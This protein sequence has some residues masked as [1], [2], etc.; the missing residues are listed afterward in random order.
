MPNRSVVRFQWRAHK[1]LWS[2]SGGRI[3][4]RV[5]GMP[6][7]ELETTGHRSGLT[8][9][10]LITYLDGPS[11]PVVF[12][13]NAGLNRDPAW[14][15]NLAAKPTVR[16]RINRLW[17]AATATAVTEPSERDRL[18]TAAVVANPGYEEYLK[19]IDRPVPMFQFQVT[20]KSEANP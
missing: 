14:V 11:G 9:S 16:I 7:L 20:T 12:G 5:V 2:I 1:F 19:T 10:I 17:T 15:L 18:W 13:T 4:R 6:V 8:R 3:G